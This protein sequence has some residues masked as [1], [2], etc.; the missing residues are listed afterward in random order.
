MSQPETEGPFGPA[1]VDIDWERHQATLR[2]IAANKQAALDE[3][4]ARRDAVAAGQV[5]LDQALQAATGLRASSLNYEQAM[6]MAEIS[7][8]AGIC[9]S[10]LYRR[11]AGWVA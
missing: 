2:E 7:S 1:P 11:I 4:R 8:A 5:E 6:T 3:L 10:E 9:R